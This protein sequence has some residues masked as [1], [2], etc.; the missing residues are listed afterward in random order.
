M[1]ATASPPPITRVSR[2]DWIKS[3]L[4]PNPWSGLLTIVLAPIVLYMAYR[5]SMFLF[6]NGRWEAVERN[7]TLFMQGTFPRDQQWRLVAQLTLFALSLGVGLGT[8]SASARDRAMEAG[9]PHERS[10]PLDAIRRFWSVI[11]FVLVLLYFAAT[12]TPWLVVLGAVVALLIG[13]QVYRLPISLRLYG[14]LLM[15]LFLVAGFQ[16]VSGTTGRAWVVTALVVGIGAWSLV[17]SERIPPGWGTWALKTGAVVMSTVIVFLVYSAFPI[18]GLGWD[19]WSGLHLTLWVS[20]LAIILSFPF[21]L[22]LALARRSGLPALRLLATTYIELIRGVPLIALLFMGQYVAGFLLPAGTTL[23]S[24]SRAIGVFTLFTAAYVAEIVRGGLQS[25][26]PGQAEAG[27][28]LGLSP[29]SVIRLIVLPQ[30]LRAVIPAMVGQ[31]IS[32]FKDTSLLSILAIFEFFNVRSLIHAQ[33]E[34]RGIAHAE[35][36]VFVAFGYWA[37]AFAMSRESQRLEGRLRV[38]EA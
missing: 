33:P 7:L 14:W 17:E 27:L 23:S 36:L 35:T 4:F 28:A 19:T 11:L 5:A 9:L 6:V 8:A 29:P 31:F 26:P 25:L 16:V 13:L 32:L 3:N 12:T 10:T 21:G 2:I 37:I 30:A 1:T 34:F 24:I 18:E 15:A 22:M 38:G 20:A